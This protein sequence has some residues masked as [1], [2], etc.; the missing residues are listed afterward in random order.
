MVLIMYSGGE[1]AYSLSSADSDDSTYSTGEDTP[2]KKA[3]V[4]SGPPNKAVSIV[5]ILIRF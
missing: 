5:A 3:K 2:D 1:D 4:I